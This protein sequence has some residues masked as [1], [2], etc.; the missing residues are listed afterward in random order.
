MNHGGDITNRRAARFETKINK[1]TVTSLSLKWTVQTGFDVSATPSID[2]RLGVVYFPSWDGC[3]YAVRKDTG[4]LMWKVNVTEIAPTIPGLLNATF[5]VPLASILTRSSPT[6][7]GPLLVFGLANPCYIL[8]LNRSSGDLAWSTS[9][10]SH[11]FCVIT[12]SGTYHEG[13]V[14]LFHAAPSFLTFLA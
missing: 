11:P 6:I 5:F 8:A 14:P 10:D 1:E 7:A 9:L 13:Y 12:Q 4:E 3:Q 2:A